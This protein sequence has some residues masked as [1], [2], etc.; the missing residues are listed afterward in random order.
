MNETVRVNGI[1]VAY[2]LEGP[3]GAPA[4]TFSNSLASNLGMWDDQAAAFAGEYR[5]LRYDTRGATATRRARRPPVRPSPI[6]R[7][8]ASSRST[9]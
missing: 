4:L 8:T 6:P 5:V 3:E 2:R 1:D 7:P 9:G